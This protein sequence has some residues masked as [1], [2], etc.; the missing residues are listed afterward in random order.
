MAGRGDSTS[1]P[2]GGSGRGDSVETGGAPLARTSSLGGVLSRLQEIR[3][4]AKGVQG[5]LSALETKAEASTNRAHELLRRPGAQL[6]ELMFKIKEFDFGAFFGSVETVTEKVSDLQ[7]NISFFDDQIKDT[8]SSIEQT[9]GGIAQQVTGTGQQVDSFCGNAQGAV[10][11]LKE[12]VLGYLQQL[13]D[14]MVRTEDI[15]KVFGPQILQYLPSNGEVQE[16]IQGLLA[17]AKNGADKMGGL[18]ELLATQ[19]N[20]YAQG[21]VKMFAAFQAGTVSLETLIQRANALKDVLP[22]GSLA[23]QTVGAILEELL[24]G[25]RK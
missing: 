13:Q 19:Q 7:Q 5:D 3:A 8:A 20:Q 10:N 14:G 1:T 17:A 24:N 21:F 9:V 18:L 25:G 11:G 12:Q 23:E 15:A 2:T 16:R 22:D 4:A 6:D